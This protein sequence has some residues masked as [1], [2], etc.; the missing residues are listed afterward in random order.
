MIRIFNV[1]DLDDLGNTYIKFVDH[2]MDKD[3]RDVCICT[4]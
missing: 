1:H 4:T 2:L 3:K